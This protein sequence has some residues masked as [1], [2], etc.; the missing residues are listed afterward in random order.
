MGNLFDVVIPTDGRPSLPGLLDSLSCSLPESSRVF[1]VD[2]RRPHPLT[3][4]TGPMP[5]FDDCRFTVLA[6]LERGTAAARNAGW[7]R[8]TADWVVFLDEDVDLPANWVYRLEQDL[9]AADDSV[10]AVPGDN[11]DLAVRRSA[12]EATGG[13]DEGSPRAFGVAVGAGF[14]AIAGL[15]WRARRRRRSSG[16]RTRSPR[17]PA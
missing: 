6:S 17:D 9:A 3:G 13:F 1:V 16:G 2:N 11:A 14:A 8:S 10:A 12:L 7:R 5:P 15:W 4:A